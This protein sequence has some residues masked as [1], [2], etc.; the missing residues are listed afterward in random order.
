MANSGYQIISKYV[1]KL[2]YRV[3]TVHVH[4]VFLMVVR[5]GGGRN[6]NIMKG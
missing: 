1:D 5:L 3:K 6:Q 4:K 2:F